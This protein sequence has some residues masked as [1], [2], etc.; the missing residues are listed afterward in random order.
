MIAVTE[1]YES[2][3]SV[4]I[5]FNNSSLKQV[6]VYLGVVSA[7]TSCDKDLTRRTGLACGVVRNSD[8]ISKISCAVGSAV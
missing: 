7:N 2:M 6:T 5:N 4:H 1:F 8:K 3:C